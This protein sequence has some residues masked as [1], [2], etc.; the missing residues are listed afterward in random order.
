VGLLAGL[1]GVSMETVQL[2]TVALI[3]GKNLIFVLIF[4]LILNHIRS[5]QEFRAFVIFTLLVSLVSALT[6]SPLSQSYADAGRIHGPYGE[7]GNIFA[8]YLI[9]HI[10]IL[11]GLFLHLPT[12]RGRVFSLLACLP[13][14][15]TLLFTLSRTSYAALAIAVSFFAIFKHRRLVAIVLFSV[16]IFPA[17]APEMVFD[18]AAT[19]LQIANQEG[20]APPS[21]EAR[22]QAWEASTHKIFDRPLLGSGPGSIPF[23]WIDNEYVRVA[24][25]MGIIGL[26][27]FLW[28]LLII[29]IRAN[30]VYNTLEGPGIMKGYSAGYLMA[31][32]AIIVHGSGATSFT[33]IRTMETFMLLTGLMAVLYIRHEKWKEAEQE[34][35]RQVIGSSAM[36]AM[37]R[38]R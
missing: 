33:A 15:Y 16:L 26:M 13:L 36:R 23:G 2:E 37:E 21:W 9:M 4:M 35:V 5:Y 7:T 25:D 12:L 27:V 32:V 6:N 24:V 1:W 34:E 30:S 20:K 28:L 10:C 17:I 22:V 11:L 3:L 38:H 29:G 8:G 31:L 19:I 18:R 14:L